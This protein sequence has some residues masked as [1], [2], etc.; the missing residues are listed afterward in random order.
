[1]VVVIRRTCPGVRLIAT[2]REPLGVDGEDV[3]RVPPMV[4]P[5]SSAETLADLD[6][7]DAAAL[8]VERARSRD[9]SFA[10]DDVGV[11]TLASICRRLD[12]LP[13]AIEL[14]AART[15][16][17]SLHDLDDRLDQR[18]RLLTGG[19]RG[20]MS[21]QQTLS[22]M[23]AWSYDLLGDP[24]R[25]LLRALTTF[26]GTFNLE[27]AESVCGVDAVSRDD[28]AELLSSL[29]NK[30][31]V[32]VER[33]SDALRYRLL[34]TIRQ[35]A[36]ERLSEDRESPGVEERTRR[37]ADFYLQLSE[38]AQP[39]LRAGGDQP[40]WFRRIDDE[41]GNMRAA[42]DY[43]SQSPGGAEYALRI[44]SALRFYALQRGL[45]LPVDGI[46]ECLRAPGVPPV[47]RGWGLVTAYVFMG[48]FWVPPQEFDETAGFRQSL[49]AELLEIADGIDDNHLRVYG[50]TRRWNATA[51]SSDASS[52]AVQFDE[53]ISAARR[54]GDDVEIAELLFLRAN[55]VATNPE[56]MDPRE[57][58]SMLDEARRR[59]R[60]VRND[61]GLAYA[62]H[63][64]F[65]IELNSDDRER[66]VSASS[67]L[68]EA[69]AIAEPMGV[70]TMLAQLESAKGILDIVTG[71]FTS[72]EHHSRRSL[73]LM[74]QLGHASHQAFWSMLTL[75][76]CAV[77]QGELL[78]AVRLTGAAETLERS[79]P[80]EAS[81][82][83]SPVEARLRKEYET[84]LREAL[85]ADIFERELGHGSQLLYD[86]AYRV[87]LGRINTES[88]V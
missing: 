72:A 58:G 4:L 77:E 67:Y 87:A 2:S 5:P 27:G 56:H 22:A 15:A 85:G 18:F 62:L 74:R 83:W 48:L 39:R 20:E 36:V 84:R 38:E 64:S 29:V 81:F 37:H 59:Y 33:R 53:A 88:L 26:V 66:I 41:W 24:E 32:D 52:E 34:E 11:A 40:A 12:G 49:L 21:R 78:V 60:E 70:S 65:I 82:L 55:Y 57:V 47:V 1:M 63:S 10:L 35:F 75:S 44:A 17:M 31:L 61:I 80:T 7:C 42:F 28:V 3:Y 8:F 13:L 9:P 19:R 23:V 51:R 79:T 73:R 46:L 45:T 69:L 71:E 76:Y 50:L 68:D 6:G 14:A 30:C 16:S 25:E 43:F 54:G 86:D